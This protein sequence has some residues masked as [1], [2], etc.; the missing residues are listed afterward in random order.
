MKKHLVEQQ[1]TA[2]DS[3][4]NRLEQVAN[5]FNASVHVHCSGKQLETRT[6]TV[7]VHATFYN[8]LRQFVNAPTISDSF[9]SDHSLRRRFKQKLMQADHEV[10]D[11]LETNRLSFNH[12]QALHLSLQCFPQTRKTRTILRRMA[13]LLPESALAYD[14]LSSNKKVALTQKVASLA[15]QLYIALSI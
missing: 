11:W 8:F 10:Y 13:A 12:L 3:L 6:P 5:Q 9:G 14:K 7:Q 4:R 1:P 15:E 2:I